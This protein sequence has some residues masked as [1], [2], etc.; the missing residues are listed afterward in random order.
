[1]LSLVPGAYAA[2]GLL[3]RR[4]PRLWLWATAFL[5]PGCLAMMTL[6]FLDTLWCPGGQPAAGLG[7]GR[8]RAADTLVPTTITL[9]VVGHIVGTVLLVSPPS[10]AG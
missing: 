3:R 8:G 7:A 2:V 4:T 5:L 1:M 9:F 10:A 6:R